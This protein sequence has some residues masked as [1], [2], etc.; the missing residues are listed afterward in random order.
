[1]QRSRV[2]PFGV[3]AALALLSAPA[4]AQEQPESTVPE[5]FIGMVG[6]W[7]LEQEDQSLPRCAITLSDEE[8]IGGWAIEVP[9]PCPA[10]Y[11]SADSLVAWNILDTDMSVILIDA[12]RHVTLRLFEDED[13][14]YA[15]DPL[16][17]PRFYMLVPW[18][19]DGAGGEADAE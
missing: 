1:M 17:L 16:S 18:D 12:E 5:Q 10:P 19:E 9:E 7:I 4:V 13:G 14:L 3:A 6:D 2:Y 8:S 15:S 11:P